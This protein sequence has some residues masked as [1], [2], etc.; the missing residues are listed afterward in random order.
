MLSAYMRF[1][2]P[3][4]VS[5]SIAASAPILSVVGDAS[6]DSFFKH[7]TA[8]RTECLILLCVLQTYF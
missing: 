1:R 6:R 3:N 7:V 4:V 2:Y 8:V 5:G